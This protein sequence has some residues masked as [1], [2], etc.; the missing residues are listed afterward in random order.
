LTLTLL[1]DPQ[2]VDRFSYSH[3]QTL[4]FGLSRIT[5]AIVRWAAD[6]Y[7]RKS[8]SAVVQTS[9]RARSNAVIWLGD[10]LDGGRR[11]W[12]DTS[13]TREQ[14]SYVRHVRRFQSLC[15]ERLPTVY[16]PGNHD[17]RIPITHDQGLAAETRQGQR[18]WLRSW[19][20]SYDRRSSTWLWSIGRRGRRGDSRA[21]R[22]NAG[23][24][25]SNSGPYTEIAADKGR[26]FDLTINAKFN[27][28]LDEASAFATHEI[29]LID[30]LELAGMIAA[31]DA[32]S[33]SP[34]REVESSDT[35]QQA[36]RRFAKT[37]EFVERAADKRA[38]PSTVRVL[39]SHI[40]LWRAPDTPCTYDR[41]N[42]FEEPVSV[43][44]AG[45][46][47][48]TAG[49]I[50]QGVDR[51]ATYQNTLSRPVSEWL[52]RSLK[53]DLIFSG[54]NHDHCHV[55]HTYVD[56]HAH[57]LTLKAFS[58]TGGVHRPGYARLSL[59]TDGRTSAVQATP[60]ALPDQ[61][62]IWTRSY[63]MA[64][65]CLLVLLVVERSLLGKVFGRP[66]SKASSRLSSLTSSH[67]DARSRNAYPSSFVVELVQVFTWPLLAW[68]YFQLF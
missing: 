26:D 33:S 22:L 58:M 52:L 60:C 16:V 8:Y 46:H 51:Y 23:A 47:R 17:V 6:T 41:S 65:P 34:L 35:W 59:T 39:I 28:M 1:A 25:A 24:T 45:W 66:S 19:G 14:H 55:R 49:Q 44:D 37:V 36:R 5:Y 20:T 9:G 38:T 57:E 3:T 21:V 53:P 43:L 56:H 7:I 18:R 61:V 29:L 48:E 62:A 50:E 30:A 13:A 31:T 27:I 68:V 63:P 67:K 15:P 11:P 12:D 54:D 40:P 42:E 4:P 32:A 2:I 64:V 10:L